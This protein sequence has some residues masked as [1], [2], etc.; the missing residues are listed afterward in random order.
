M[1]VNASFLTYPY[2]N[3]RLPH[4]ITV[5]WHC[6]RAYSRNR[7]PFPEVRVKDA[8]IV[9]PR[10]KA[11]SRAQVH[12][13]QSGKMPKRREV[14]SSPVALGFP[15]NMHPPPIFVRSP[16][17]RQVEGEANAAS[18]RVQ[19]VT[20]SCTPVA[21]T[22]NMHKAPGPVIATGTYSN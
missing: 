11:L 1:R 14:P 2:A 6:C 17:H 12:V 21:D 9:H 19:W 8:L 7:K 20:R 18:S 16:C 22:L 10:Y 4:D 3:M 13:K 5:A 15:T